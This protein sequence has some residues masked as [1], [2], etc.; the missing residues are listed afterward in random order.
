MLKPFYKQEL[1]WLNSQMYFR[2]ESA[3]PQA[4]YSMPFLIKLVEILHTELL[5][6]QLSIW[7]WIFKIDGLSLAIITHYIY[8]W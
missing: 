5:R 8:L 7:I 3:C 2:K 6:S 1:L 4:H